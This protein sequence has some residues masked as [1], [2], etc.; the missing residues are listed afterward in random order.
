[1][2]TREKVAP[3]A[4]PE[5]HSPLLSARDGDYLFNGAGA[6]GSGARVGNSVEIEQGVKKKPVLPV[7]LS[8][9]TGLHIE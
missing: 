6:A 7:T 2:S 1:L 9:R 4:P 8:K 3:A 5:L